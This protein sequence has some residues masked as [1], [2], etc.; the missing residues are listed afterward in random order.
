M[1]KLGL[2][3]MLVEGG[4]KADNLRRADERIAEAAARGA[5]VVLLPEAM[6]LG[7]THSSAETLADGIPAGESCARL[8]AA[9]RQHGVYICSGLIERTNDSIYNA[10]VLINPA[11]EVILH[12]RKLNELDIAQPLYA[13]GDRV[14][15]ARTPLATF[16]LMI[17]ADA[18]ARGQ[19]ISRTLGWMGADVILSPCAWAVPA[20][21]DNAR[22][23]YGQ[24]W[25]DHYCP[26]ARD[27]RVWI[28]GVSNVGW[29]SDGPWSGRKCIGCSL[30]IDSS[31]RTVARGPYGHDAEALVLVDI[32]PHPRPAQ[33]A[34]WE[35]FWQAPNASSA[36]PGTLQR[37]EPGA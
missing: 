3:Q 15:A 21:H 4:R 14:R 12:H 11:G 1:F 30:V 17:C 36:E 29:I 24:L 23:R 25:L 10:A 5:H 34:N 2:I 9:A 28:A 6:P 8:G 32:E 35:V 20:D 13:L 33:G 31:G 27:F 7:W 22:D 37:H 16:G 26:V 19:V 18:F